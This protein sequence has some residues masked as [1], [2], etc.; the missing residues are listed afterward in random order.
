M[1]PPVPHPQVL[2]TLTTRVACVLTV[3][4]RPWCPHTLPHLQVLQT[5]PLF[6]PTWIDYSALDAKVRVHAGTHFGI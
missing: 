1:A 5:L 3:I 6:R 4:T 2:Q